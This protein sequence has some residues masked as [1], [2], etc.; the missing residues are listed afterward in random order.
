[1][2]SVTTERGSRT[3]GRRPDLGSALRVTTALIYR[4]VSK[5]EMARDRAG[6]A[7]LDG[8]VKLSA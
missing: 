4:R 8:F 2:T 6:C 1:M 7:G 5:D 3:N